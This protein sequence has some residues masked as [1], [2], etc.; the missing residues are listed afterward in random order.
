MT[1]WL[2]LVIVF[3]L[4]FWPLVIVAMLSRIRW[5]LDKLAASLSTLDKHVREPRQQQPGQ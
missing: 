2:L 1:Y 4:T 5:K 3:V